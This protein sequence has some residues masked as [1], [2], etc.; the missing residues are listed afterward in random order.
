MSALPLGARELNLAIEAARLH[1]G[2]I[3]AG[4]ARM[5]QRIAVYER[6]DTL[7]ELRH[8]APMGSALERRIALAE[9]GARSTNDQS[10]N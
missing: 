2:N 4:L 9:H 5:H 7:M 10:R 3:E 1:A 8:R 6:I